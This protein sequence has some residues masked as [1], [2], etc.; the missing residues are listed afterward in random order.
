MEQDR[1]ARDPEPEEVW[2]EEATAGEWAEVEAW[3]WVE[4]AEE[5]VWGASDSGPA[6]TAS[7]LPVEPGSPIRL[8]PPV[9]R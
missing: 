4:A 3:E 9:I 7:A 1:E 8:E 6:A 2:A 5:A